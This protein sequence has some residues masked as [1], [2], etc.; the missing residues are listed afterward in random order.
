MTNYIIVSHSTYILITIVRYKITIIIYPLEKM[1]AIKK[2]AEKH[3]MKV[4]LD[5]A[6]IFNAVVET[7]IPLTE[8]AKECDDITFCLSKGLGCPVGSML[9]GD[10]AFIEEAKRYRKM[11][12]GGMRQIGYLAAAG[13][14][15]LE[16]HV[17]RLK[18]DHDN[19]RLIADAIRG[20]SWGR[21]VTCGTNI[22]FF[23]SDTHD[24]EKLVAA[25]NADGIMV[26]YEA[27]ACR[28]VTNIGISKSDAEEIAAYFRA[29]DPEAL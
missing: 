22:L 2:I 19:C 4:H 5:G 10:K 26:L 17:E 18:E 13:I 9:S 12:G 15:A 27:G 3:D 20:T 29:F 1:K 28:L 11:L 21:V 25:F 6:R 14:Y 23:T 16:N 24:I 8:W 7:G